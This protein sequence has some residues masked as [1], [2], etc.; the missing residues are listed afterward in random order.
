MA[1]P[2]RRRGT[3]AVLALAVLTPLLAA[4]GLSG[5]NSG[6]YIV[7]DGQVQAV[8]VAKRSTPVELSGTTLDGKPFVP[9]SVAGKVTV[10]NVWGAWC[11]ACRE[12]AAFVQGAHEDLGSK[13][14]FVGIDIRDP[15]AATAQAYERSYDV[16]Y[17]SLF[18][19]DGSVLGAFPRNLL[20]GTVPATMVLDTKGRVAAVIRGAV[21]SKLTLTETVQCVEDPSGQGCAD[22]E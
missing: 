10:V 11:G 16:T 8:A 6:G 4:C 2:A 18:S 21:P 15:S 14:A 5:T 17:P 9:S 3:L 1:R 20:P 22:F 19:T 7:G 12:E 13:V